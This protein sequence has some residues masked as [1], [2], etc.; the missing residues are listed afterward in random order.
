M[1]IWCEYGLASFEIA[2]GPHTCFYFAF[3]TLKREGGQVK[4]EGR[5]WEER[6]W[7]G[8]RKRERGQDE[9][10]GWE[11]EKKRENLLRRKV[12]DQEGEIRGGREAKSAS[13]ST[14][15]GSLSYAVG[16]THKC[17]NGK[18]AATCNPLP[19]QKV[20]KRAHASIFEQFVV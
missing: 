13:L 12:G 9:G 10:G 8:R 4:R 20:Y 17:P 7:R 5:E 14:T 15:P 6:G 11:G 19:S 16:T 1:C 2:R 18:K 3:A